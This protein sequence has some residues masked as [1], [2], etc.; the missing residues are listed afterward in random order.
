MKYKKVTTKQA[1]AKFADMIEDAYLN[2]VGY[3]I[4]KFGKP[5]ALV[6]P[7]EDDI[8]KTR[9]TLVKKIQALNNVFGIW[10]KRYKGKSGVQIQSDLREKLFKERYNI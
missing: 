10:A 7:Y 8:L 6:T 4:T 9:P 3:I 5:K 1:R 2:N